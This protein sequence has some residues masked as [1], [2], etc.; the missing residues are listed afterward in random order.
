MINKVFLKWVVSRLVKRSASHSQ[1]L[2]L[3]YGFKGVHVFLL[4]IVV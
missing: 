3:A 1:S 2:K 4:S